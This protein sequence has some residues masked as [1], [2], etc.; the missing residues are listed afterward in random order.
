MREIYDFLTDLNHNNSKEWF[1]KNRARYE[2]TR[3]KFL[4]LTSV[5]INEI[6]SFDPAIGY[7]EPKNCMFRL[8]RDVR[9]SNDKRPFKTNYGSFIARGGRSSGNP[10]Y[11]F[12]VQP[13]E[14]FVSAGIY[15]PR[16]D[17]LKAIREEIYHHPDDFLKIINNPA[18][19]SRFSFFDDDKLKTAPQGYPKDWEHI[20]LLRY[21][22]YAPYRMI[23]EEELFSADL[24][25]N[26]INDLRLM[27]AFN[28]FLYDAIGYE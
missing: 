19:K 26:I 25:E 17:L 12:Q 28:Q 6:R 8:Y 13:G 23:G 2:A 3:E 11:Y 18:F 9:F 5:L 14:S 16:P 1:D 7:L 4:H 24:L 10:G 20:D 21:K 27:Q 15:M 22:S